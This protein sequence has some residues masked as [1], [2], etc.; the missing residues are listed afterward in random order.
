MNNVN[1]NL[2]QWLIDLLGLVNGTLRGTIFT[3][4]DFLPGQ[5]D[6]ANQF[7][8][9]HLE[10]LKSAVFS[11]TQNINSGG[12]TTAI[13]HWMFF[14]VDIPVYFMNQELSAVTFYKPLAY[15]FQAP[16]AGF[17]S[18]LKEA[19]DWVPYE[20]QATI[21]EEIGGTTEARGKVLNLGN[22]LTEWASMRA[23]VQGCDISLADGVQT[24]RTGAPQRLGLG[25]IVS[26]LRK[27]PAD[28][29][30]LL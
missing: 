26:R 29:I 24:I 12:Q 18:A 28:N 19:Q 17:A 16:P 23:L 8:D 2:P 13:R 10:L 5:G 1:S 30:I 27:K 9:F 6:I 25:D 20:G 3:R 21:T 14:D 15:Q 4:R 11:G 22:T 7:N